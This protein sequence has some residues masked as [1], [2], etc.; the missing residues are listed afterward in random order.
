MLSTLFS[1]LYH[2]NVGS[3]GLASRTIHEPNCLQC[4]KMPL[5]FIGGIQMDMNLN[6]RV[7]YEGH[8]PWDMFIFKNP[9]KKMYFFPAIIDTM[10]ETTSFIIECHETVQR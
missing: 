8:F 5:H 6:E 3:G 7:Q 1:Y 2:G 9:N 4:R 10:A